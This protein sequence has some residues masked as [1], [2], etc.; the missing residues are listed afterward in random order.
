MTV[1]MK[2]CCKD[3]CTHECV[4]ADWICKI[5]ISIASVKKVKFPSHAYVCV[6]NAVDREH[7]VIDCLQWTLRLISYSIKEFSGHLKIGDSTLNLIL[8][9]IK[10]ELVCLST[11]NTELA[12][13]HKSM[14][15][16]SVHVTN[17]FRYDCW[18]LVL[19]N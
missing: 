5:I 8:L 7:I 6:L 15:G 9:E 16:H 19:V 18:G 13:M 1:I 2:N 14:Y 10:I 12:D 17:V 4:C 3:W 11:L